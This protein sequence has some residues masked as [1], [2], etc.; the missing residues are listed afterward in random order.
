MHSRHRPQPTR[1]AYRLEAHALLPPRTCGRPQC[2]RRT[3]PMT[4]ESR[5][6]TTNTPSRPHRSRSHCAGSMLAIA[7][8]ET[9]RRPK[10]TS[11]LPWNS[12]RISDSRRQTTNSR[13]F[14]AQCGSGGG[15]RSK[16]RHTFCLMRD[17]LQN[18]AIPRHDLTSVRT[19]LLV[20]FRLEVAANPIRDSIPSPPS[21]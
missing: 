16:R 17:H 15:L 19:T 20:R 10:G 2:L 12:L 3:A 13:I 5:A 1:R 7:I 14:P 6:P 8:S 18:M 21:R 4:P 9:L 11:F